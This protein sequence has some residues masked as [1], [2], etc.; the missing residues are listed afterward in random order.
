[1]QRCAIFYA[2]PCK[3]ALVIIVGRKKVLGSLFTLSKFLA[4]TIAWSFITNVTFVL[5]S[6]SHKYESLTLFSA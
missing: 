6:M 5:Q 1:M 3:A 2:W 4:G